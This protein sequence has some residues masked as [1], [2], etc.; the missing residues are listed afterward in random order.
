ML[1]P[2]NCC[3]GSQIGPDIQAQEAEIPREIK[4]LEESVNILADRVKSLLLKT[5]C[6]T[7]QAS[8]SK[9]D[10]NAEV[11]KDT[12]IGADLCSIRLS[13]QELSSIILDRLENLGV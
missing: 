4:C 8:E 7:R 11:P 9:K 12:P 13:I 1:N 2:N 5:N 10:C 3:A 6:I